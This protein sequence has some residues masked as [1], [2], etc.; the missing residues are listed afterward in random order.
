LLSLWQRIQILPWSVFK[1]QCVDVLGVSDALRDNY[2]I[3]AHI[4]AQ[5]FAQ[6]R[7][8]WNEIEYARGSTSCLF[9]LS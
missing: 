6:Q 5:R 8:K 9:V 2:A 1:A 3:L 4:Q 7:V